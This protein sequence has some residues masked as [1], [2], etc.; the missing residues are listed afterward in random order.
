[1]NPVQNTLT[2]LPVEGLKEPPD[3][4]SNEI[5]SK[6]GDAATSCDKTSDPVMNNDVSCSIDARHSQSGALTDEGEIKLRPTE[7]KKV[8]LPLIVLLH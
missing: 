4:K 3:S 5:V 6:P 7:K 8:P 1:M 2:D